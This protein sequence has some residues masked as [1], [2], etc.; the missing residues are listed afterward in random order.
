VSS[1]HHHYS[2]A[3]TSKKKHDEQNIYNSKAQL[4]KPSEREGTRGK[5]TATGSNNQAAP[6]RRTSTASPSSSSPHLSA[7]EQN[8]GN[9]PSVITDAATAA[10]LLSALALPSFSDIHQDA[11]TMEFREGGLENV[12]ST[13]TSQLQSH[14]QAIHRPLP[15]LSSASGSE[16]PPASSSAST[17]PLQPAQKAIGRLHASN[18]TPD[19]NISTD[20]L[21]EGEEELDDEY[22]E[23]GEDIGAGPTPSNLGSGSASGSGVGNSSSSSSLAGRYV[24]FS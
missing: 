19:D 7:G 18:D 6:E 21:G 13:A 10:S 5:K 14:L 1:H 3:S 9:T 11:S 24:S 16:M 8:E 20:M 12:L 4:K 17:H 22:Y 15:P 23:D 2:A